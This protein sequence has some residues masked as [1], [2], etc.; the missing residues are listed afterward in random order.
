M[1]QPPG[2][3][4]NPS[5]REL[6]GAIGESIDVPAASK[7]VHVLTGGKV[8]STVVPAAAGGS[9]RWCDVSDDEDG[10]LCDKG[11]GTVEASRK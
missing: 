2:R 3:E 5:V 1:F 7:P 11:G 8:E 4:F 9:R 10:P 6:T